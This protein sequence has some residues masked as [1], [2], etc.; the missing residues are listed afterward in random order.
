MSDKPK[1]PAE[2]V[3][4]MRKRKRSRSISIE[5]D[6]LDRLAKY[7]QDKGW[8]SRSEALRALV[9]MAGY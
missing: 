4:A 7:Q 6:V 1:T 5:G 3:A 2:R 8:S 9:E